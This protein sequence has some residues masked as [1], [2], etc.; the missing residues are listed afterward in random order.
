MKTCESVAANHDQ[1]SM[2]IIIISTAFYMQSITGF[3]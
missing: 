3:Y 1:L 2:D